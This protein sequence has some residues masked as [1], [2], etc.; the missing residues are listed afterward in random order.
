MD[1]KL[2]CKGVIIMMVWYWHKNR[3]INQWNR[4]E[5]PE[6]DPQ[7]Y[8]QLIFNKAGKNIQWKKDSLFNQWCWE[9][10]SHMQ[11]DENG[12]FPYAIHKDRFQNG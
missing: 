6:I 12:P 7:L 3:H 2:Y 11:K 8:C 9:N 5:N 10:W 4:V 1:F